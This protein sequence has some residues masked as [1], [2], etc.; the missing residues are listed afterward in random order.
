MLCEPILFICS[1]FGSEVVLFLVKELATRNSVENFEAQ[2]VHVDGA[3]PRY[4][5]RP[6]PANRCVCV[7][8]FI[9]ET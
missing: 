7:H 1:R 6:Q 5:T 4:A 8:G 3:R 9:V 2:A